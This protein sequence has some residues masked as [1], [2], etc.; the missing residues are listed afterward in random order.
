MRTEAAQDL[1]AIQAREHDIEHDQIH[2]AGQCL[3]KTAVA[4]ML[5]V[6]RE[7]LAFQKFTEE[8]AQLRIVVD[9]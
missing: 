9:E 6:D 8:V 7:T 1:E 5:T 3:G 2:S 4:F